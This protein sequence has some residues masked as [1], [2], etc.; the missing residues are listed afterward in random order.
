[1]LEIPEIWSII[2]FWLESALFPTLGIM[3]VQTHYPLVPVDLENF[4]MLFP[5]GCMAPGSSSCLWFPSDIFQWSAT[6]SK[7]Y[8]FTQ[9][10]SPHV[11]LYSWERSSTNALKVH[12]SC[13]YIQWDPNTS[14][15]LLQAYI[16]FSWKNRGPGPNLF[17]IFFSVKCADT[18]SR[19]WV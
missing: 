17:K 18:S 5:V 1:M 2:I 12:S 3:H 7:Q 14:F 6:S 8:P 4:L 9:C 16:F 11:D 15:L 10:G 19:P 13:C